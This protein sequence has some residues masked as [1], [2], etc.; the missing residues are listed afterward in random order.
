LSNS[1]HYLRKARRT[2][3]RLHLPPAGGKYFDPSRGTT[4][5]SAATLCRKWRGE[6]H[7]L[8]LSHQEAAS[9][10]FD[11]V[12]KRNSLSCSAFFMYFYAMR[13]APT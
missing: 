13:F 1:S 10:L 2:V 9:L 11:E 12:K 5:A 7:F 6:H 4:R 8:K 3:N